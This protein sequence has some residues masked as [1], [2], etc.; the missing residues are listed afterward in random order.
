MKKLKFRAQNQVK[1]S[2][3]HVALDLNTE[4]NEVNVLIYGN[5]HNSCRYKSHLACIRSCNLKLKYFS[6]SEDQTFWKGLTSL[7]Q[8]VWCLISVKVLISKPFQ[9]IL[10]LIS[11]S[12]IVFK[13][14]SKS[15]ISVL[16]HHRSIFLLISKQTFWFDGKIQ[17]R[18]RICNF[19]HENSLATFWN[20]NK[21][22]DLTGKINETFLIIL[23]HC[24]AWFL[25]LQNHRQMTQHIF[26]KWWR[27]RSN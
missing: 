26:S 8:H 10:Y 4:F 2:L 11:R 21:H 19:S 18:I 24:V 20:L 7:V 22:S 1:K 23:Q 3:F 25:T 27:T 5:I 6:F 14:H 15:L 9:S 12:G 13:N 17:L 16:Q